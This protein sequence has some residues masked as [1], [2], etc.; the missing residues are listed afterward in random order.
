[1][2]IAFDGDGIS[3]A[4]VAVAPGERPAVRTV[5]FFP[6]DT[7][8]DAL[9]KAGKELHL[10]NYRC[11]M[12]LSGG[13][14]Q[15]LAV[16]A[17]SVPADELRTAVRWRLKDLLDFPVDE[18]TIDV[19]DIPVDAGATMRAQQTLF[20]VAARGS[21]LK[22]RQKL[23]SA[24]R[25][26]LSVVDVPELAQRNISALIEP[27]GRGVAMLSFGRDGGLLTVSYKG[28]LYLARRIDLPLEQLLDPD[29]DRKQ[30]RFDRITLEL[31]RSLDHFERQFSFI[32]I[33]KLVLA[34]SMVTG[35][36]E[37]LSSN[38]YMP[39]DTLDLA[40]VFDLADAPQLADTA[41]QHRFFLPL[42]AALREQV[43][44]FNPAFEEQK[45]VFAATT[46]AQA[47]ALLLVGVTC[48]GAYGSLRVAALQKQAD[49]GA[50]QLAKKQA[51]LAS[52]GAE[53][54]PRQNSAALAAE[55][56]QAEQELASLRKVGGLIEGGALGNTEGYS[57][58]F[59]ALARQNVDG[60]WLTGV[61]IA[62]AGNEIGVH[63]RALDPA[64]LP[65]YLAGLAREKA[66]QGKAFGSLQV[67]RPAAAP[68]TDGKA[69]AAAPY[70][71]FSLQSGA[72]RSQS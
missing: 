28:E 46:M 29:H 18:A 57:Q 19:L 59:K 26:G 55:L 9:E 16:E 64:L 1:M 20:V 3:A 48:L 21:V 51:R 7:N 5:A 33:A 4:S 69:A 66:L 12:L 24:A 65:G 39:V 42:G 54:A 34:P 23:F 11:T 13:E 72:D 41:Q 63:G 17:P 45:Q 68:G 8:A 37:Y 62:A 49:A 70:V 47:L 32:S 43:N 10:G 38:L 36:D 25:V 40:S 60:L 58:Y 71:E 35:L 56:A 6:G 61:S 44:L 30:Q 2:A 53:F 15:M 52:V 22:P 14:Y 50:A 67:N 27:Q 31:Q